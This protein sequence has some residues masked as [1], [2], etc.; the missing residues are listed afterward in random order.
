M[1]G[2]GAPRGVS[3]GSAST[4]EA[5]AGAGAPRSPGTSPLLRT[6]QPQ[7]GCPRRMPLPGEP[8]LWMK[9]SEALTDLN[10][11]PAKTLYKD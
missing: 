6:H 1:L 3:G 10:R 4:R 7:P 8:H 11:T 2:D 9:I 5:Q